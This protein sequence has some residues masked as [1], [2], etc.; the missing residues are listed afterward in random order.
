M[1]SGTYG[2]AA[3]SGSSGTPRRDRPPRRSEFRKIVI[4]PFN[5]GP[6]LPVR[7]LELGA[8]PDR[9]L[10]HRLDLGIDEGDLAP[11]PLLLDGQGLALRL[12]IRGLDFDDLPLLDPKAILERDV[13][14]ARSL[15]RLPSWTTASLART[16]S[17]GF[18]IRLMMIPSN[19][20][21]I[22]CSS[23]ACSARFSSAL[24]ISLFSFASWS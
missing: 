3:R 24:A 6:Q 5:P 9:C 7:I 16:L 22:V 11:E 2:V 4:S 13:G 19:G 8:D 17:P 1:E 14:S 10:G 12:L 21:T 15:S 23:S 18:F 20:A